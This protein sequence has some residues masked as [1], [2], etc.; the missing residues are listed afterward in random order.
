MSKFNRIALTLFSIGFLLWFGGSVLRSAIAFDLF[1]PGAKLELK[2][3]YNDV[4]RMQ[5]VYLFATLSTYTITGYF[6]AFTSALVLLFRLKSTFKEKGW[7]MMAFILFF[8]SS[9]VEIYLIYNDIKLAILIYWDNIWEFN[10]QGIQDYFAMRYKSIP[11]A[12]GSGLSFLAVLTGMLYLIWR[13]LDKTG[14][15]N[16]A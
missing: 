14:E 12:T 8:I 2:Q 9:P 6:L 15:K 13:P 16:E 1:E 4:Q 3:S 10:H 7:L 5:N 11:V